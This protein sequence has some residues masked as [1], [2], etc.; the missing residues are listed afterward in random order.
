MFWHRVFM[1]DVSANGI[2]IWPRA[3]FGM[4]SDE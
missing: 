4:Y 2:I 3:I 1:D